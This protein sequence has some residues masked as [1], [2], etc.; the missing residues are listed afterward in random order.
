LELDI[1]VSLSDAEKK[2]STGDNIQCGDVFSDHDG[3]VER[4]KKNRGPEI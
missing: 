3:R 1:S 4:K 2:F